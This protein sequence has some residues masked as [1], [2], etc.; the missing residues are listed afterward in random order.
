MAREKR[1][2]APQMPRAPL[3]ASGSIR[4]IGPVK[5]CSA[6]G[7]PLAGTR[8]DQIYE[9]K[10]NPS[11]WW[12]FVHSNLPEFEYQEIT[13]EI[14]RQRPLIEQYCAAHV[15]HDKTT[16]LITRR[17]IIDAVYNAL[18]RKREPGSD[19]EG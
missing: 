12:C 1:L 4:T 13:R 10:E 5:D 19:D 2:P 17:Q 14:H 8:T 7:C 15:S 18:S 9:T 6:H 11:R 16:F 3:P